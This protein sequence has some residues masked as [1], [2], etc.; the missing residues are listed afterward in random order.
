MGSKHIFIPCICLIKILMIS[1]FNLNTSSSKTYHLNCIFTIAQ[2]LS[3][4]APVLSLLS[5]PIIGSP[6]CI[7]I[8]RT[9]KV[10]TDTDG[11]V[12]IEGIVY[13]KLGT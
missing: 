7:R 10:V 12:R 4:V 11:M 2:R 6:I 13:R 5:S 9:G 8:R 1:K 3:K